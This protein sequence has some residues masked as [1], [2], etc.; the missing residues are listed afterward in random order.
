MRKW[1]VLA[2]LFLAANPLSAQNPPATPLLPKEAFQQA[3]GEAAW[4][5]HFDGVTLKGWKTSGDVT[6]KDGLLLVGGAGKG[7]LELKVPLGEQFKILM[8][9]RYDGPTRPMLLIETR[10]FF[11]G[12][13][14]ASTLHGPWDV[15]MELLVVGNTRDG[16]VTITEYFRIAEKGPASGGDYG[17]SGTPSVSIEVPAGV[18][19]T[20]KRI[21]VQTT[22]PAGL[23]GVFLVLGG[24]MAALTLLA[25]L[26]WY[27][28]RRRATS[29]TSVAPPLS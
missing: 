20:I 13:M 1:L 3:D 9:C 16:Q 19:M 7:K 6:I 10:G 17:G 2:T 15:W 25:A 26:G 8:E 28:R 27:L 11:S 23:G 5:E 4:I 22:Q 12:G 29:G 18:T 21:R 14:S 24:L